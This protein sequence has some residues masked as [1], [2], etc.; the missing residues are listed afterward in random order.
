MKNKGDFAEYLMEHLAEATEGEMSDNE[1]ALETLKQDLEGVLGKEEFTRSLSKA[2]SVKSNISSLL[3]DG[4][5]SYTTAPRQR[6]PSNRSSLPSR[7]GVRG[8][9]GGSRGG[10]RGGRGGSRGGFSGI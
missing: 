2:R 1:E 4:G 6:H 9:R 5:E 7:G 10:S 3:S 8:G